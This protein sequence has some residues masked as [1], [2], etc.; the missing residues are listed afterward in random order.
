MALSQIKSYNKQQSH[1]SYRSSWF[2]LIRPTTLT[3]TISPVLVGTAIAAMRGPIQIDLFIIILIAG[4]FVQFAINMLNDYF[5]YQKG[6]DHD[7]WVERGHSLFGKGPRYHTIPIVAGGLLGTVVLL[8]IWLTLQSNIF[9]ILIGGFGFF[10]GFLYSAGPRPLCSIGLG[11]LDASICIGI[12]PTTLAYIVQGYSL[13]LTIIIVSLPFSFLIASM[14][15]ANNIRDIEKD[16]GIRHTLPMKIGRIRSSRLLTILL[17]LSYGWV[18]VL[19]L[20][21]VISWLAGGII[22]ALPLA[23]R[24]HKSYVP[25]ANRIDEIKGMKRAAIH[26]WVFSL[27]FAAGLWLSLI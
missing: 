9:V 3:G 20:F 23:Y 4:L 14:I 13:D 24:L 10:I 22:L 16:Q 18:Y 17:V 7:R 27:L 11:E 25:G 12:I 1:L 21:H 26:H 5:D 19:I 2:Q 6:Q 15:L 8:S